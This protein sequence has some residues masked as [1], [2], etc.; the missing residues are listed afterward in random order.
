MAKFIFFLLAATLVST[1]SAEDEYIKVKCVLL[2][3]NKLNARLSKATVKAAIDVF[4]TKG[5]EAYKWHMKDVVK[6]IKQF[7]EACIT[8]WLIESDFDQVVSMFV[9]GIKEVKL[10]YLKLDS[11]N[12]PF[13]YLAT[14]RGEIY[15]PLLTLFHI[16]N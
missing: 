12:Y 5:V 14:E 3:P 11:S 4:D 15:S 1:I 6:N 16:G 8:G 9:V 10:N 2:A 7:N 13:L